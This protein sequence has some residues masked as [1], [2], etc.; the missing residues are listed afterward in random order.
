MNLCRVIKNF[1]KLSKLVHISIF[2]LKLEWLVVYLS[3]INLIFLKAFPQSYYY[4]KNTFRKCNRDNVT[5]YIDISDY[6]QWYLYTNIKD[7]SWLHVY[8]NVQKKSELI[9]ID[10]G[11]NIGAF[12]LKL[13]R[14]CFDKNQ[15]FNIYAFEPNKLIFNLL[16]NNLS[17]NKVISKNIFLFQMPIGDKNKEVNFINKEKNSGGS[18]VLKNEKNSE[19]NIN[20]VKMKQISLDYFVEKNEIDHVDIIKIDVEG[21]EPIVLDG[22]INTIKKFKPLLYIEI[23]PLWFKNIGRSSLELLNL[24]KSMGYVIFLDD[25]NALKPIR[26][27]EKISNKEQFN[28]LAKY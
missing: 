23:T 15:K 21:Y 16:K 13:A 17:L 9:I 20:T 2:F 3:G 22:C 27:Y 1:L 4:K 10:V 18:K 25:N 8:N 26:D 6:M 7:D 28:I 11:A 14:K 5:F 24:L 12:S 19:S